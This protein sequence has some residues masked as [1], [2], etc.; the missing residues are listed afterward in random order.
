M[1]LEELNATLEALKRIREYLGD[2]FAKEQY[3]CKLPAELIAGVSW[4]ISQ[5][6]EYGLE[7]VCRQQFTPESQEAEEWLIQKAR[8]MIVS[9]YYHR[10]EFKVFASKSDE[11]LGTSFSGIMLDVDALTEKCIAINVALNRRDRAAAAA[12]GQ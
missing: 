8:E 10:R 11:F 2:L 1:R 9:S 7:L 4:E 12:Q 6:F 5:F 3:G